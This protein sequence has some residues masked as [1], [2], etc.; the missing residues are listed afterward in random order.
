MTKLY[1]AAEIVEMKLPNLPSTK[2]AIQLRAEKEEWHF[3]TRVGLGGI[4]KMFEIPEAYLPGYVPMLDRVGKKRVGIDVDR[5]ASVAKDKLGEKLDLNR[6][7]RAM[8]FLERYLDENNVTITVERKS[9][10]IGVLYNYME[11][12]GSDED[13]AQLLKLVA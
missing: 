11:T 13:V 5:I 8:Q 2:R 1:T 10:I 12:H 7:K 3:E 6:L 9:E 4:R